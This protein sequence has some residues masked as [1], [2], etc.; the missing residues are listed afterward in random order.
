MVCPAWRRYRAVLVVSAC[1]LAAS[2]GS[3]PTIA[4]PAAAPIAIIGL[5]DS[6]THGTMD[7]TNNA[8]NTSN[9]YLQRVR[10]AVARRVPVVFRQPLFDLNEDRIDPLHVPTNLAV[11]GA[12][13]FTLE[14]LDYYKRAGV[15]ESLPSDSLIADKLLPSQFSD[16]YDKVLYP[17]NVVAGH[18]ITQIGSAEW[19]L[20]EALP[21]AGV[22]RAI[23]VYWVGNNDSSTSAL[24]FGGANPTFMP[25]PA[26]QLL[27]VLPGISLLLQFGESLGV[28]STQPYSAASVDRN[29]TALQDFVGAQER[30]LSRLMAAGTAG[31]MDNQI[32]VL[33]L[34]Y[35]SAVGYLMDSE[36]IEFYMRKVNPAY[37]VPPSFAR[38]A[39]FGQPITDPLKGDRI[40]FL[41]FGMMYTLLDSGLPVSFVNRVLEQDGQQRDGL[42]LSEAEVQ[43]IITRID[44]Y[45][46]ALRALAQAA[47]PN[48]HIVEIGPFLSK[49]LN[50]AIPLTVGG[51]KISRKWIRGSAFGFD[52]VHPAYM[53][54]ALIANYVVGRINDEMGLGAPMASLPAAIATDPYVDR[55][56]D[57]WAA[58]PNYA[59]PGI[60]DLLFLFKDPDDTNAAVQVD[61]PENV[62]ELIRDALLDDLL[63]VPELR[64]EAERLGLTSSR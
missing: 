22:N 48:V 1:F 35:Y 30:L 59:H 63:K 56:G 5:G 62:W 45:N 54:H 32:F 46:D 16:K 42:V 11:D 49:I 14:G 28:L 47:G 33:T 15:D 53:G 51:H 7:A 61:L 6:L 21:A 25:I 2:G 41:T 27:P 39:P 24:G 3:R 40:S 58:G 13:S 50:G 64:P 34:A 44:Q 36:D 10:D 60:T 43:Q 57:G 9:A 26:E 18:P 20:R 31:G 37:R 29:L 8:I 55:D 38:V 4:E 52:G 12:D 17:I 19:L 23:T